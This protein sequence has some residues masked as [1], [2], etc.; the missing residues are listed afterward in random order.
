MSVAAAVYMTD[1]V[2]G[3]CIRGYVHVSLMLVLVLHAFT[4]FYAFPVLRVVTLFTRGY[5]LRVATLLL[6]VLQRL[7]YAS[8]GF[9]P[10]TPLTPFTSFTWLHGVYPRVYGTEKRCGKVTHR[11][12]TCY[13]NT[14]HTVS[15]PLC[16]TV[17]ESLSYALIAWRSK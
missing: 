3:G 17:T 16:K 6:L 8:T 15:T 9:T 13:V 11:F 7:R 2:Y 5:S 10:F 1:G 14:F 4:L 12:H